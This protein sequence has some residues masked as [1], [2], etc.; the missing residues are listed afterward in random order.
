MKKTLALV[1]G[2]L[3]VFGFVL[4]SCSS[5]D[6][7]TAPTITVTTMEVPADNST[8][9]NPKTTFAINERIGIRFTFTDP[10]KDA[11]GY[12]F[13]IKR[14]DGT[15]ASPRSEYD[16]YSVNNGS[17]SETFTFTRWAWAYGAA[18]TYTIEAY[19]YDMKDNKGTTTATFTVQ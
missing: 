19:A 13:T 9:T 17:T 11:K 18:G 5:E 14:P 2:V 3:L 1:L 8:P 10:D 16:F 4:V 6:K 15:I 12:G 7:G